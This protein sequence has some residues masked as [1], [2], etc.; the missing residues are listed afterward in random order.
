MRVCLQKVGEERFVVAPAGQALGVGPQEVARARPG[1]AVW[2][3]PARRAEQ[4]PG[5]LPDHDLGQDRGRREGGTG[6]GG[7]TSTPN[8]PFIADWGLGAPPCSGTCGLAIGGISPI[9]RRC[10]ADSRSLFPP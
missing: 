8:R 5:A 3:V 6:S 1:G 4:P 10:I 7:E 2:Q 9:Y